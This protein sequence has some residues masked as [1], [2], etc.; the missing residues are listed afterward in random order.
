MKIFDKRPLSLILCMLLGGFVFFSTSAPAFRIAVASIGALVLLFAIFVPLKEFKGRIL[1][2]ISAAAILV[3]CLSSFLYFDAYFL[4]D[5]R[6][7][8]KVE[9]CGVV[10]DIKPTTYGRKL[11]VDIETVNGDVL[12]GRK[13]LVYAALDECENVSTGSRIKMS[14]RIAS[15]DDEC[16]SSTASYYRAS[17][18]SAIISDVKS[19]KHVEYVGVP[20]KNR[21]NDYR[22]A[23]CRRLIMNSDKDSGGLLCALLLG[24]REYLEPETRHDFER[25]GMSH[26]L[27]L[28][29]MHL[30]ILSFAIEGLLSRLGIMKKPRKIIQIIFVI[31]YMALTGFPSSVMRA[32]IM[33]IITSLLFLLSH[34]ADSIT[35]LFVAVTVILIIEPYAVFDVG[36]WLS[37]FAT[38][39]ILLFLEFYEGVKSKGKP[40]VKA[41]LLN[42]LVI[43]VVISLF[44]F[45]AT[46]LLNA[47]TF[48]SFSLLAPITTP[49][50][51][52][53]IEIYM[54]L[55]IL[56]LIC[57]KFLSLGA[58]VKTFGGILIK[59]VRALS[60]INGI[61][62]SAE[63]TIISILLIVFTIS[64]CGFAV[65]NIKRKRSAVTLLGCMLAVIFVSAFSFSLYSKNATHFEYTLNENMEWI[66]MQDGDT[67]A[68]IDLA[69][70][71]T[72]VA[73]L[74]VKQLND[75]G[76]NELDSYIFT[77][78]SSYT[79]SAVDTL[80]GSLLVSKIYLPVPQNE[81]EISIAEG[82]VSEHGAS[83]SELTFYVADEFIECGDFNVF[84]AYRSP[85][86][87]K[88]AL[89]ILYQD[90]FYTYLS[91]GMLEDDTKNVALPLID[92]CDTLI[93]GRHGNSY[94]DYKFIYQVKSLT[95]LVISSKNLD[96][97]S[98]TVRYYNKQGT[99]LYYSP[100][101][102][103]L[104]VE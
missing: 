97:P 52:I 62:V 31:L 88:L 102:L 64:L 98:E 27:A 44:A 103:K 66:M 67:N 70:P 20:M 96:L 41:R 49:I 26:V 86:K 1:T 63:Y 82:I 91:S 80:L 16:D 74:E 39:G 79:E 58:I 17:G 22:D 3:G 21:I 100:E 24:E 84:P 32:G 50:Y 92:G 29:G 36:L 10:T 71:G 104:Y 37:A 61:Y 11:T 42:A 81:Y 83:K 9:I 45:G 77:S 90:E 75:F 25:L 7:D 6:Y 87:N 38:L 89:T 85:D 55:G 59:S 5:E 51:S 95:K 40:T 73:A 101:R 35:T 4:I 68:I 69:T 2:M 60:S 30:A 8:G 33:L 23:L 72:K 56:F 47:D 14:G 46:F 28:S 53:P 65:L 94:F 99:S 18:Y 43:P 76:L 15:F 19:I 93:L 13:V 57:G 34:R 48:D 54:Y 12:N 78:Y